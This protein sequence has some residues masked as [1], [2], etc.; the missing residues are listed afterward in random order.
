ME[1]KL[2][3]WQAVNP[4]APWSPRPSRL[5]YSVSMRRG[6]LDHLLLMYLYSNQPKHLGDFARIG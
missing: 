4:R 1:C 6:S 2:T 3:S 5:P